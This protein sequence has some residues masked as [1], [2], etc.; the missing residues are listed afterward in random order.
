M[1]VS[2]ILNK[3][4]AAVDL[5]R[6]DVICAMT[7][8]L[9]KSKNDADILKQVF[10]ATNAEL[11]GDTLLHYAVKLGKQDNVR[12]LLAAGA[13]PCVPNANNKL[14]LYDAPI[15]LHPVFNEKLLQATAKSNLGRV[16]QMLAAGVDVNLI[17][18]HETK[19]TPLH[20]AA[21]Y[22][23]RDV[24]QCLCSHGAVVNVYNASGMTPLHEAIQRGDKGVME[25]LLSFG[26]DPN[27]TVSVGE[28]VGQNAIDL[29]GD[30]ED[31]LQA[32]K[33]PR[34]QMLS[35][36]DYF[37]K[38]LQSVPGSKANLMHFGSMLSVGGDAIENDDKSTLPKLQSPTFRK[39]AT[40]D[41]NILS[42]SQKTVVKAEKLKMLWPKPQSI[43]QG[44]G[45]PFVVKDVISVLIVASPGLVCPS[46]VAELWNVRR[47]RFEI[48]GVNLSLDLMTSLSD[49]EG[50]HVICHVNS[51]LCP[52]YGTYKLT[53]APKQMKIVCGTLE[54]LGHAIATLLQLMSLYK[55]EREIHIPTLLIDDWPELPYRGILFDFSQGR[56]PNIPFLENILDT[57]STLKV[58]QVHL[59]CR[60]QSKTP[61]QWQFCFSRREVL[62]LVDF[63]RRRQLSLL[64]VLEVGPKVQFEELPQLHCAFSDFLVCFSHV[65]FVSC[66]PRL[67]S[68]LL[69]TAQEDLLDMSDVAKYIPLGRDQMLQL[70]A[71]PIHNLSTSL[72]QQLPPHVVFNEFGVEADHDFNTF[73][74]SLAEMGIHFFVCPGT[75]AWNSLAGC[76]EAALGNIYGAIKA[77]CSQGGLGAVVCDWTG[78]C[79]LTH[80]SF[81]WPG[82]LIGAG[83]AWNTDCSWDFLLRHLPD[84]LSQ[85]IYHDHLG[86]LGETIVELG[87]AETFAIR[88]SRNQAGNDTHNLPEQQGSVLFR[89]LTYPDGV[90]LEHLSTDALQ[91][92]SRHIKKCQMALDKSPKDRADNAAVITE[93]QLTMEL[94]SLA[95]KIGKSLVLAGRKPG[96]QASAGFSVVNFG[97]NNLT[98][99]TRTDLANRLLELITRYREV[100]I[101]SYLEFVGLGESLSTL[102]SLLRLLLPNA[103]S[104]TLMPPLTTV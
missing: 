43:V 42:T 92:V 68:F 86:V 78:K 104:D 36:G 30:K 77:A 47:P 93:L 11:E 80:Q 65:E 37:E 60:F 79:H 72:M 7:S 38:G 9:L 28:F 39:L 50:P 88:R 32:L 84:L 71:Y 33:A 41:H 34:S 48:L 85:Y 56:I 52:G 1:S 59:Y 61:P 103:Q 10:C 20:W 69:N 24:V 57:L 35:N 45:K 18:S 94:M 70:C 13:D 76:P 101:F 26:A 3:L 90:P 16:S 62:H 82:F 31:L 67:S 46:D 6:T 14:P 55:D 17:D 74:T 96:S 19:N 40:I 87:R 97:I 5:D 100:W 75:A 81:A 21:C 4:K 51:H 95:C 83:L 91:L 29:A 89:L 8:E 99:T 66:G 12:A 27:L 53:I 58:N 64:P 98:A 54:S 63:C 102:R 73:C 22:G 49:R 15:A 25:E 2:D 23:N 44:G